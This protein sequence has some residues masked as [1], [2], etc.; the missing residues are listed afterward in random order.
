MINRENFSITIKADKS[1]IWNALW[2]L[3]NYQDWTSVFFEG[4]HAVTDNWK[5]G[6]IVMFMDPKKNGMYSRIEQHL[7]NQLMKF[8]HIGQVTN[9]EQLPLNEETKKWSGATEIYTLTETDE[10]NLL[11][12]EIDVMEEHLEMM[13]NTF[14]KA[15][16]IVRGNSE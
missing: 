2:D 7:P 10:G 14:S 4:S 12:I 5:E 8:K 16:E 15:L 3:D 11:S 13:Q 6:S 9:G 1:K